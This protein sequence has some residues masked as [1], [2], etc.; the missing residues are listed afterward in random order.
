[1]GLRFRR[2]L[3]IGRGLWL[4]VSKSG[5]STSIGTKGL[6]FNIGRRGTQTTVGLP[7]SGLSFRS[8]REPFGASSGRGSGA[9]IAVALVA[10]AIIAA[11]ILSAS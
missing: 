1:M 7:G 9:M 11:A 5:V 4:N 10:I 6:T 3:R 8:K 2:R